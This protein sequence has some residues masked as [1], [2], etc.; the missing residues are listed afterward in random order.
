[1]VRSEESEKAPTALSY[2][3]K[4]LAGKDVDLAKQYQGKVVLMVNVA[5]KCGQTKQYEGAAGTA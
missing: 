5:S 3:M 4:T 2:T 1:M